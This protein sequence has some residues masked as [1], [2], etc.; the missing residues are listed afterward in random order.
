[1][2]TPVYPA[3]PATLFI[4]SHIHLHHR[5]VVAIYVSEV[6]HW[7]G[8]ERG[9]SSSVAGKRSCGRKGVGALAYDKDLDG[10]MH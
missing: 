1:M 8:A 9:L 7:D 4:V 5:V 3:P 10:N 6:M 2:Y